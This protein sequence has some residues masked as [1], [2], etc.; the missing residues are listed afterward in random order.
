MRQVLNRFRLPSVPDEVRQQRHNR[1]PFVGSQLRH[2]DVPI[3]LQI[4]HAIDHGHPF[5][6]DMCNL[7]RV[8]LKGRVA[9]RIAIGVKCKTHFVVR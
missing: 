8:L 1:D 6:A 5:R 2:P 3:D 7:R 4:A 9:V